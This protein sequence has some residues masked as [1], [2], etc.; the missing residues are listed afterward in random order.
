VFFFFSSRRRHTRWPRDWSSDVCSSDLYE[1]QDGLEL[2]HV[3]GL[4]SRVGAELIACPTCGRIQVDL[5][6]LV[7]DVRKK[8]AEEISV[9]I[10][11][12]EERRVGKESGEGGWR[13]KRMK[14]KEHE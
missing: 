13:E 9:P 1:V 6:T 7:Q 5:Y 14:T 4:R 10:K 12:S 8:L 3:L 2:L 11:R